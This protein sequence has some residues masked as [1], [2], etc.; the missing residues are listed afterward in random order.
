VSA[1]RTFT[2]NSFVVTCD[3]AFAGDGHQENLFDHSAKIRERE[4]D[5]KHGGVLL[6]QLGDIN[7]AGDGIVSIQVTGAVTNHIPTVTEVQLRF[8]SRGQASPVTID[9]YD[10]Y[11]ADGAVRRRNESVARV[12]TL[13][14]HRQTG[15]A[16]MEIT[17][18]SVK[19]KDAGDSLWQNF[20]AGVKGMTVNL[21][22]KPVAIDP[23]G[24][25]TM[26]NFGSALASAAPEFT[27]PLATNYTAGKL[28]YH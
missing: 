5:L 18:T 4:T 8:N 20:K 7:I 25:E 10:V 2:A 21:F 9:L 27:F 26:L 17:V 12:S 16:K 19:R 28:A 15:P 3:F 6:H 1:K 13:T 23:A 14:F 22:I 11:Y 24:N